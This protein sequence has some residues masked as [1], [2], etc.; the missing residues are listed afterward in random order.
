MTPSAAWLKLWK[1]DGLARGV[2]ASRAPARG[3]P[4]PRRGRS[5]AGGRP[6][7]SGPR[8]SSPTTSGQSTTSPSARGTP[9]G[10]VSRPSSGNDSTSVV[11]SIPRCSRFSADLVRGHEGDPELAVR[12]A[13]GVEHAPGELGCVLRPRTPPRSG[14]S[15]RRR[16]PAARR[17]GLLGVALVRLDDP[18]H[19]LVRTTSSFPNSTKPMS[20]IPA[21]ISRTWMRPDACSRGRSTCVTSPVTT[22][23]EPNPSRV[24]NICICS[25]SCS[26]PRRGRRT[27]R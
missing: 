1:S 16:S 12:H 23:F 10:S 15:S 14:S 11:S 17:A 20:S 24:R 27:S 21:R 26:G 9:S 25:G 5:R 3:A 2:I 13:L 8:H 19:E 4:S 7:T 6:C 18:L 22:I